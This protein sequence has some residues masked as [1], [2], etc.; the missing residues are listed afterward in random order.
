M[1][2]YKKANKILKIEL[3]NLKEINTRNFEFR[4]NL[5]KELHRLS[6]ELATYK[7]THEHDLQRIDLLE[8]ENA[9]LLENLANLNHIILL[10]GRQTRIELQANKWNRESKLHISYPKINKGVEVAIGYETAHEKAAALFPEYAR[11]K[12]L[13]KEY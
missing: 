5:A 6:E 4:D 2:D 12:E 8:T 7:R 11:E 1:K 3:R 13:Q 10:L 9:E